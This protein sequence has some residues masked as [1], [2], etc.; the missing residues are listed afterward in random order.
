MN[1]LSSDIAP[2]KIFPPVKA[3]VSSKSGGVSTWRSITLFLNPGAYR[4]SRLKQLSANALLEF[5]S[6]G[7]PLGA[8]GAYCTNIDIRCLPDGATVSSTADGIVHSS[9]GSREG[10]PYF[11][12]S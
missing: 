2:W 4:S 11:A 1:K 10:V 9:T 5:A 6:H 8:Y 12:S 3:K 7:P